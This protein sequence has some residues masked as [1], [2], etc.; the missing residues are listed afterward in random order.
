MNPLSQLRSHYVS[1]NLNRVHDEQTTLGERLSD[2]LACFGG[3][4][5][6][7]IGF[8]GALALWVGLNSL[9]L[10]VTPFD[11]YPYILL[12]LVLS[13][14]AA[15][16]API[17]LMSQNR[18]AARDRLAAEL[19]YTCTSKA[20]LEVERLHEKLDLL[21]EKQWLD[22]VELQQHQITLLN[23]ILRQRD[24]SLT[25][26][27]NEDEPADAIAPAS[28]CTADWERQED[29]PL[30]AARESD[31]GPP[32]PAPVV[33]GL[34]HGRRQRGQGGLEHTASRTG[35]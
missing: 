31:R 7:I 14:L 12:N 28:G 33:D 1:R 35:P 25:R 4:W 13:C 34:A 19:D 26:A 10:L 20:E 24:Q 2:G 5:T 3:S 15:I 18:Q 22:L 6:F 17:I 30:P 8:C 27:V 23:R 16:Q 29:Q 21:R 32:R 9:Q 11:P